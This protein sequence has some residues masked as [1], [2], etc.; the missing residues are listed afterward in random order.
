MDHGYSSQLVPTSAATVEWAMAEVVKKLE[1]LGRATEELDRVVG[2]SRLVT[3]GDIPNLPYVEAIVKETMRLYPVA[4]LLMPQQSRKDT[5][6][7]GYDIPMGT[8][9]NV[10]VSG[11][12][13]RGS[14]LT[15]GYRG[16][17]GER[18]VAAWWCGEAAGGAG[19]ST[20][21]WRLKMMT[22]HRMIGYIKFNI[23]VGKIRHIVAA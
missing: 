14:E 11:W 19:G 17:G 2:H 20:S 12:Y 18:R 3:E 7:F 10:S 16:G 9:V 13:C 5:S 6:L 4:P 1:I 23:L 8:H 15:A 21:G 22:W